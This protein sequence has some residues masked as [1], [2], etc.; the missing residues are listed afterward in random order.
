M[1]EP[2]GRKLLIQ[3]A[4]QSEQWGELAS[5]LS[6]PKTGDE[7][8]QLVEA[9]IQVGRIQDALSQVHEPGGPALSDHVRRELL[10]RL[11][12]LAAMSGRTK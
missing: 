4:E 9:L 1:N 5:V 8:I 12:R 6:D 11:E 10:E 2:Y 3:A 7:R